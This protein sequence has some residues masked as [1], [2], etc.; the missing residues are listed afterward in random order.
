MIRD[1]STLSIC[2]EEKTIC[3]ENVMLIVIGERQTKKWLETNS[4][5]GK[6]R[7]LKHNHV[8][9]KSGRRKCRVMKPP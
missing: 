7:V 2:F 1:R 5:G 6:I 9:Y 8:S 4:Y 3:D